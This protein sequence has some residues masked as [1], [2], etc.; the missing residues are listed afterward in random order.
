MEKPEQERSL[1]KCGNA[2]LVVPKAIPVPV[3]GISTEGTF[4]ECMVFRNG[5]SKSL[6]GSVSVILKGYHESGGAAE[7]LSETI[8][9]ALWHIEY[10]TNELSSANLQNLTEWTTTMPLPATL[11]QKGEWTLT[12]TRIIELEKHIGIHLIL[13]DN[14]DQLGFMQVSVIGKVDIDEAIGIAINSA[15][16]LWADKLSNRG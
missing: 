14:D 3:N 9:R 10:Q 4:A 8:A 5:R 7:N 12:L 2:V 1:S 6:I 15:R 13:C 16:T 11:F